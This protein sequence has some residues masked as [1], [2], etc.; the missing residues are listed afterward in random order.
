MAAGE[1]E[2]IWSWR[3]L[4]AD[5]AAWLGAWRRLGQR[6]GPAL[7]GAGGGRGQAS[8]VAGAADARG[9]YR[10]LLALGRR[11]ALPRQRH[12]TPDEYA[13]TWRQTLPGDA[14]ATGLTG[15]YT[16][17]RYGPPSLAPTP[18]GWLRGLL[19]RLERA[20]AAPAES[21]ARAPDGARRAPR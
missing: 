17:A 12:Q 2:S 13:G 18:A 4:W 1:R 14:E 9:A 21:P 20:L 11:H 16:R 7:A 5:L 8:D 15:A 10:R 19:R 3:R 6:G